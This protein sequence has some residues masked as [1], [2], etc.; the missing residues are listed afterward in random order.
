MGLLLSRIY[1]LTYCTFGFPVGLDGA[2]KTTILYKLKLGEVVTSIPTI[3]FNVETVEYKN[4][5]LTVWDVGG[6]GQLRG[7]WRH[8]YQNANAV[9]FVVD[10]SDTSRLVEARNEIYTAL[11]SDELRNVP[12][13][14]WANKQDMPQAASADAVL[15]ALRLP[16][17]G[18]RDYHCEPCVAITHTGLIEG[19][20]WLA[21]HIKL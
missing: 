14:V 21:Q 2:G 12:V 6:Q 20:E 3:G 1:S 13:L 18:R 11:T 15:R 10:S 16:D 19:L 17:A 5:A 8:Y 9:I 4:L 7:L